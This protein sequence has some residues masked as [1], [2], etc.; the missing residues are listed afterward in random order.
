ME[1]VLVGKYVNT[2]SI[3][4]E[5][6]IKSNLNYKDRIFKIGNI[7]IIDNHEFIINSYR[8]HKEYDMVTFKDIN[9]INDIISLKG[10]LVYIDKDLI[11][12]KSFEYLETD[13]IG[14]NVY[15]NNELKGKV[16]E[17]KY[18]T[19]NKKLL[20]INNSYV[21]FELIKKVDLENK[22]IEI[23]EVIGLL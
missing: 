6:K 22:R 23:E 21:P 4:G 10:S 20:V 18:L 1:K 16:T 5:I 9:N 7:L 15:Q 14:L 3:K 19:K 17:I 11:N 12:L 2:H 13:L 8:K